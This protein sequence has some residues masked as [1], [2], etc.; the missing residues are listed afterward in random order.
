MRVL[1]DVQHL[2]YL[3]HYEPVMHVLHAR[4]VECSVVCRDQSDPD[5][6]ACRTLLDGKF[7]VETAAD[8][9]AAVAIAA[10]F[11]PDWIIVGNDNPYWKKTRARSA[12]LYH[13][14]GVKRVYYSPHLMNVD[15]RF[16]EGP[17]RARE[18]AALYP[19]V[20][21]EVT[22]YT[23]VDPLLNG[24]AQ[25]FDL[26]A[27]G[28]DPQRPTLL[29][30]PTFFP[31]SI[32][33][34]PADWPAR[35]AD[36]NL[37]VKPHQFSLTKPAYREQQRLFAKWQE[38][39]N[40]Y[41]ADLGHSSLVPFMVVADVLISETSSAL[42]E[43]A[44]LDRP[45]IWCDFLKLRWSYRGPFSYRLRRRIDR[46]IYA[47]ADVGAHAASPDDLI[48]QVRAELAAPQRH[49]A[50]RKR[51]TSELIGSTDGRAAERVADVL[52][53]G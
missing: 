17:Y 24:S 49:A 53:A 30:A 46:N 6:Q 45:V 26:A 39:P 8:E 32:E 13:G 11:A 42:F 1:F 3:P 36:V 28:L 9:T 31:S 41:V 48:E 51:I 16:V 50:A 5:G 14:N 2:Y 12:L 7:P 10:R 47:Y 18:L 27:H 33:C 38:Y 19:D 4:G 37:L 25:E 35:L 34:L 21:L 20:R 29:Y 52:L 44:A 40:V 23:K 43:F 22:G 15:L